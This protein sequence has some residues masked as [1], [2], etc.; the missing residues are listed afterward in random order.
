M[1]KVRC[2]INDR[3]LL[4]VDN[5]QLYYVGFGDCGYFVFVVC[6]VCCGDVG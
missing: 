1:W 3:E 4:W 2:V 6:C 5:I